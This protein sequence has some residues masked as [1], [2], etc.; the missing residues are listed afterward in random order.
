MKEKQPMKIVITYCTKWNYQ[1][2]AS[3]LGDELQTA[4]GAEVELIASSGG[5]FEVDVDGKN[6]FSKKALSRFPEEGEIAKLLK[7][8][9]LS[10]TFF[11]LRLG[12]KGL[13]PAHA[14][15]ALVC[16]KIFFFM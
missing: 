1:P 6:I 7:G 14:C 11:S 9:A 5:V 16:R 8:W 12:L 2:R 10:L 15:R 3:S 4:F 13:F